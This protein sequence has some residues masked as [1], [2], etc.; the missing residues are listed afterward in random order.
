MKARNLFLI[1]AGALAV[2]I[3]FSVAA[4]GGVLAWAY[5]TQRDAAG[6]FTTGSHVLRTNT[7]AITSE[8]ID[9]G[10]NPGDVD[11]AL[12]GAKVRLR[13]ENASGEVP[14]FVGVARQADVTRY[15]SG[16]AHD[17]VVNIT[18]SPFRAQ[19]RTT[20]GGAA[21]ATPGEQGFWVARAS[22]SGAQTLTWT[23][24]T[25][26][27]SVVIMNADA[28]PVVAAST[29]VGAQ[30]GFVAPLAGGLLAFGLLALLAGTLMLIFGARGVAAPPM[31]TPIVP[32]HRTYPVRLDAALDSAVSRWMW[33]V[34]PILVIP[35]VFVLA[36]LWVAF[37]VL[38]IVAWFAILFTG[39]YPRGIFDFNVGVLR[40]SWRVSY[41]A[42][43]VLG[44]D[45]Y[46]PFTLADVGDYPAHLEIDYPD[47][48]SR[49]LVL[50]KSWLLAIPHLIIVGIF[51]SG[52]AVGWTQF[53]QSGGERWAGWSGGL[54]GI[55]VLVAALTLLFT[56]RYPGTVF[57]LVMGLQRWSYRVVGYV[58]LMRD[59]Y[60]PFRLDLGGHDPAS[61]PVPPLA[62]TAPTAPTAPEAAPRAA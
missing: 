46:P 6:Y 1:I 49:G 38:T 57:D 19:Y 22:G 59:E 23:A 52:L 29:S 61:P 50:V 53:Q 43:G 5:G 20:G 14:V 34:K 15:L 18:G 32:E 48:L 55:L 36:L 12:G 21:P 62:P 60:P 28:S 54:I 9:L 51:G 33:L 41:Y 44:S 42:F 37:S 11:W 35:H 8:H 26:R 24:E 16:V 2:L 17:E 56:G 4:A 27:W 7:Y 40:W 3:G 30:A 13:V 58:A 39:R 45:R 25:G 31:A 10:S 47:R